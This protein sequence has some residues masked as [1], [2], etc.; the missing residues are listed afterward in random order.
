ML[1][2]I[3]SIAP[4]VFIIKDDDFDAQIVFPWYDNG[5]RPFVLIKGKLIFENALVWKTLAIIEAY[6]KRNLNV[7]QTLARFYVSRC[8]KPGD[9]P[10]K[11]SKQ[12]EA[13]LMINSLGKRTLFPCINR[14]IQKL[15]WIGTNKNTNR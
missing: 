15:N 4:G 9:N 3:I 11:I 6:S 14:Q 2:S 5:G 7:A 12:I 1:R 10:F 13:V 8:Y